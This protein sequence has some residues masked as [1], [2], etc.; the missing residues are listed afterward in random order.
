MYI[1]EKGL[2]KLSDHAIITHEFVKAV[3]ILKVGS[4]LQAIFDVKMQNL[5]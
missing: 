2:S 5:I 3:K 4:Q 1:R